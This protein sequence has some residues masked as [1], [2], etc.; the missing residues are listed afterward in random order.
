LAPTFAVTQTTI[1]TG[2]TSNWELHTMEFVSGS[3]STKGRLLETASSLGF[4]T[5]T[6]LEAVGT[7]LVPLFGMPAEAF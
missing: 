6:N 2:L 7:N 1:T 5:A 4:N 3:V